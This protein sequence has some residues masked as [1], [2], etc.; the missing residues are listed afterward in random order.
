[1]TAQ[2]ANQAGRIVRV[3]DTTLARVFFD[4][5]EL[6]KKFKLPANV[7]RVYILL[8]ELKHALGGIH[9]NSAENTDWF[10]KIKANCLSQ[11]MV[12]P[13]TRRRR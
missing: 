5:A 13:G 3:G 9:R 7:V 6:G 11:L 2:Y 10:E 12:K 8:H 1:M 4:D